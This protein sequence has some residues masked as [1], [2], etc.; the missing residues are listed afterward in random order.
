M[1]SSMVALVAGLSL[2]ALTVEAAA[3]AQDR[4]DQLRQRALELV[5]AS[6]S[7]A[8][9]SA[10]SL[11]PVLN[12]AAQGHA[13]DMAERDYYAHVT[14]DGVTPA[15][16]YRAA[17]GGR[18]LLSGEN[19]A[20][21]TGCPA[22]AD[23][24]RVEAFHAGWMQSPGHRENI[25]KEGFDRLG[26]GIRAEGNEIYA[27]QTFAGAGSG[28]GGPALE[29]AGARDLALEKVNDRRK[30]AGHAP[31]QRSDALD[32]VARKVM[33]ARQADKDIGQDVFGL[34]PEGSEG[35]T[36]LGLRTASRGGAGQSITEGSITGFIKTWADQG[37]LGEADDTD[38][39]FA[40]SVNDEG[41][42]TAV[43]V[44]ARQD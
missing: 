25:L 33:E 26:F 34:F 1:R 43:V 37:P 27:V 10:L 39:G 24:A 4:L 28:S 2:M 18:W 8:G 14:P 5:N 32:T 41:R 23:I 7:D 3:Q 40:A 19:I 36:R 29:G 9:L 20:R 22:P 12:E 42:A 15:E 31:L 17:G 6:R 13:D 16:R 35:W 21:C 38:L 30:E 44:F 11:G